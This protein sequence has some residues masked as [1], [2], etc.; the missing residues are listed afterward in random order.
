V[1]IFVRREAVR[2]RYIERLFRNE[3]TLKAVFGLGRQKFNELAE[4]M[5]V[6]WFRT[7]AAKPGRQR[8]P[9]AGQPSKIPGW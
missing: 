5:E 1:E 7:L 4:G 3:R 8:A 6:A 9:G 2:M